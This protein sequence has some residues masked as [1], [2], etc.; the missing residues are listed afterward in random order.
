MQIRGSYHG[1]QTEIQ[2]IVSCE[3]R[4]VSTHLG[5]TE[6]RAIGWGGVSWVEEA[7][8]MSRNT[9]AAG[10]RELKKRGPWPAWDRGRVPR[11]CGGRKS[12]TQRQTKLASKLEALVERRTREDPQSRLRW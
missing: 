3:E 4:A 5:S 1:Y 7:I 8:G 10:L 2:E 12:L 11:P 9:I 6:A